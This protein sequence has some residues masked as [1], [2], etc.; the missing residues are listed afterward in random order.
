VAGPSESGSEVA[1]VTGGASGFGLALAGRLA[2]RGLR[3][4]LL[5]VDAERV[6]AEAE[7]VRGA[8]GVDVVGIG[9]DVAS[10]AAMTAAASAVQDRFGRAD[11]VVSN[12]GVQLFGAVERFRDEEWQWVLDVNVVGAA[13]VARA[14]VPLLRAAASGRL[15]FTTS[16]SVLAWC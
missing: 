3:V 12:V 7:A 16:S 9:V 15:A 6:A 10:A 2:E 14:F 11:V 8:H 5:D 1:V 13:R 4:A